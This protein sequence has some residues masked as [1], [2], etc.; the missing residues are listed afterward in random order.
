M[1]IGET[2]STS[3]QRWDNIPQSGCIVR[4]LARAGRHLPPSMVA[5]HFMDGHPS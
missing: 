4:S 3:E 5:S 2:L 1:A